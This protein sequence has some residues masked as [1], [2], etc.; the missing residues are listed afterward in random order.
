MCTGTNHVPGPSRHFLPFA[1]SQLQ[2]P[3][4]DFTVDN[5]PADTCVHA[6]QLHA[7]GGGWG[8]KAVALGVEARRMG[9][10]VSQLHC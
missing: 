2:E 6:R 5:V 7:G 10:A 1:R 9:E 3:L 8:G 4:Q